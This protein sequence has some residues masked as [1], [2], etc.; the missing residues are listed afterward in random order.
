MSS[1]PS[2]QSS[3]VSRADPV[4]TTVPFEAARANNYQPMAVSVVPESVTAATINS[5]NQ[6]Y[7][8]TG[9]AGRS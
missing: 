1:V 2:N 9:Q 8:G 5:E 4:Q 3:E 7:W 6:K